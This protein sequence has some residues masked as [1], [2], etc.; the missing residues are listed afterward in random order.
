MAQAQSK[1]SD[2]EERP[3]TAEN[4]HKY[5]SEDSEEYSDSNDQVSEKPRIGRPQN[6]QREVYAGKAQPPV[7]TLK[8]ERKSLGPIEQIGEPS[9]E[10]DGNLTHCVSMRSLSKRSNKHS[11]RHHQPHSKEHVTN[12]HDESKKIKKDKKKKHKHKD[13]DKK[14]KDKKHKHR[15]ERRESSDA[16]IKDDPKILKVL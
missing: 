16:D 11:R 1:N 2:Y 8:N 9:D 12:L 7:R 5:R 4:E 15:H 10:E 13:K 3:G 6:A 14:K